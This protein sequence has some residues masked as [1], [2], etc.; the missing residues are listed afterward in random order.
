MV[1]EVGK[2][3]DASI[4]GLLWGWRWDKTSFTYSFPTSASAYR[5]YEEIENFSAFND[6]QIAAVRSIFAMISGVTG[7]TFTETTSRSADFRFAEATAVNYTDLDFLARETGLWEIKTAEANPPELPY[8]GDP[9]LKP[10]FAQGDSWYNP[11]DYNHPTLGSYA[12]MS[13]L[14]ETGHNLGLKHGHSAQRGHGVTFPT[15]PDEENSNEFAVMTYPDFVGD[16]DV[17]LHEAPQSVT[18]LMMNDIA[19]LQYLYGANYGH[20]AGNTTYSWSPTTGEAFINGVGQGAPDPDPHIIGEDANYIFATLWDGGGI[21]TYD[22]SNYLSDLDVDL[23]PGGWSTFS[24]HQL[25]DLG[26]GHFARGNIA[27]ALLYRGNTASLIENVIGG[28]GSDSISG[29][30]ASNRFNGG[31]GADRLIGIA[32]NDFLYGEGG[33]DILDGGADRDVL[34]GGSGAD[35][36]RGGSGDDV[37]YVDDARDVVKEFARGGTDRVYA[38]VDWVMPANVE[39]ATLYGSGLR[40]TGNSLDN[41]LTGN[42]G[43]NR[44]DGAGGADL[45]RGGTGDDTYVV[46]DAGDRVVEAAGEGTDRVE[47]TIDLTLADNVENLT[48]RGDAVRGTG[49]ALANTIT[50]NSRGNLLDGG[51]G[52]DR[53]VGGQGDDRYILADVNGHRAVGGLVFTF[54]EVVEEAGGGIDTVEVQRAATVFGSRYTLAANVENGIVTGS[55]AFDLSGNGLANRLTG[56]GA[57]NT[58]AGMDGNDRLDGGLGFDRLVGGGGNDT[59]VLGDYAGQPVGETVFLLRYDEVVEEAGG[60]IDTVE[61]RKAGAATFYTLPDE[62]ENGR[63]VGKEGFTLGGNRLDNVLTGGAGGDTLRGGDGDDVLDGGLGVDRLEGGRGD[64]VF[65]LADARTLVLPD[66]TRSYVFDAVIEL[67]GGGTDRVEVAVPTGASTPW[68]PRWRTPR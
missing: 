11:Y 37:Y 66:G 5:G 47:T 27:N 39:I 41:T 22:L 50:G 46:D 6:D 20:N 48:L 26:K 65:V 15:L 53:L 21:D 51:A 57:A 18:S 1:V 44:I 33:D 45:M 67:A 63:I 8:G 56:N 61:V 3:G 10:V 23:A 60:G 28:S 13:V 16:P 64:D 2:T 19:A 4:D 54:D 25:A 14:H 12:F 55:E 68:S 42:A 58:L 35:V 52:F 59:Y 31:G 17:G 62:V 30:Q 36:M 9:P 29:N 24:P 38:A 34:D 7:L 43:D 32:G 40:L 49:N